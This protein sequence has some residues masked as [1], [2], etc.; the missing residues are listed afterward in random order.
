MLS[1]LQQ[2]IG[3]I[4]ILLSILG[5][6]AC[7]DDTP[8]NNSTSD[9]ESPSTTHQ[10]IP[11]KFTPF[12][13]LA[14][15]CG[16]D[17]SI[18]NN[19][20][21]LEKLWL[22]SWSNETYLW[23]NE[24]VDVDPTPFTVADYFAQLK[25]DQL[26]ASGTAKDQFHFSIPSPQWQQLNQSGASLG[27]GMKFHLQQASYTTA[28]K[29]TVTFSEPNTPASE[30]NINRGAII[31]AIDGVDVA[32]A[33]T[34]DEIDI[35][36]QGLFPT[37]KGKQTTFTLLD[38]GASTP[39]ESTLVADVFVS[40]PVKD[41]TTIT[42]GDEKIGYLLFNA[43]IAN[44]EKGLFDAIT[45]L[46]AEGVSDLILD[47][48]YNK[49]G[50]LALASQLSY[51]VV[52]KEASF[53]KIFELP[54]FNDKYP[55][56]NPVTGEALLPLPFYDTT[57]GFNTGLIGVGYPLP[58]LELSR[59]F[60]LTTRDTCSASEAFINALRGID[61]EVI[62]IGD[63]TCGKPYGFYPTPN[64]GM[65]YFSIQFKGINHKGFGDYSDGFT[66]EN[67]PTLA[68][69]LPGCHIADDLTHSLGDPDE[70]LLSAALFY[71]EQ[72]FCPITAEFNNSY[73]QT[74]TIPMID[75]GYILEDTRVNS[76]LLN[77]KILPIQK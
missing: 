72:G 77:S 25:T 6:T 45:S 27:Y 13:Q 51:M 55:Y 65:T 9:S 16:S 69:E 40:Q 35:L 49:G 66:P 52:G 21:M 39:R 28:R 53:D 41:V 14:N 73:Q 56:T 11:G 57:I 4:V 61:I 17:S 62:Q 5:L 34:S 24:I 58:S 71:R 74:F 33:T 36:N 22:R 59:V 48:R 42:S 8:K 38:L 3:V 32:Q 31:T 75:A 7:N 30:H 46:E 29:I 37:Y 10:W 50:L 2:K 70:G 18:V 54:Q 76:K 63:T 15:Q 12:N 44:A 43:H 47:L 67:N 23:Y 20:S 68:S 64:C 26:S 1:L 60:V 19:S